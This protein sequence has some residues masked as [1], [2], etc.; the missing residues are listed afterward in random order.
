[1]KLVTTEDLREGPLKCRHKC[2]YCLTTRK[3]FDLED[4]RH[5]CKDDDPGWAEPCDDCFYRMLEGIG[6]AAARGIVEM[7]DKDFA[8]LPN[9]AGRMRAYVLAWLRAQ[10][11]ITF[12]EGI[13]DWLVAGTWRQAE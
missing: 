10:G 13:N 12:D 11:L 2:C 8:K 4:T 3:S 6:E 5:E 9:T 7:A 1:M